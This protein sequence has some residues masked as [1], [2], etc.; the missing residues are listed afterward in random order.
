MFHS[1]TDVISIGVP[2]P[3]VADL[4]E[5]FTMAVGEED[6]NRSWALR[7]FGRLVPSDLPRIKISRAKGGLSSESFGRTDALGANRVQ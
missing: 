5:E 4:E 2:Q 6:D 1:D 7:A 3:G